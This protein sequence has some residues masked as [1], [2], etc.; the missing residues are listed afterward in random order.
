MLQQAIASVANANDRVRPGDRP[1]HPIVAAIDADGVVFAERGDVHAWLHP[2]LPLILRLAGDALTSPDENQA[3]EAAALSPSLDQLLYEC[4]GAD[5]TEELLRAVTVTPLPPSADRYVG[6]AWHN[7][8][9]TLSEQGRLAEVDEAATQA[10]AIWRRIGDRYGEAALLNNLAVL[11]GKRGDYAAALELMRQCIEAADA[12]PVMLRARCQ[13]SFADLLARS[14]DPTA[15]QVAL[16]AARAL[17]PPEPGSVSEYHDLTAEVEVHLAADRPIEATAAAERAVAAAREMH[18]VQWSARAT[19][20]LTR[21]RRLAGQDS[22]DT[23]AVG[24][25]GLIGLS[26][27]NVQWTCE[28]L[29]E[30]AHAHRARGDL[31]SADA[32]AAEATRV[33]DLAGL[34]G[35]PWADALFGQFAT[36]PQP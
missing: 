13:I 20:L 7:L 11:Q 25:Q 21:A 23:A 22:L 16:A 31:D 26:R 9:S 24:L 34:G 6:G 4:C 29:I 19:V 36:T 10:I 3:V 27:A 8:A 32:C 30:L 2:R 17:Q 12:L 14:G 1:R 15:A 5:G 18:A 35:T 33:A 28:A